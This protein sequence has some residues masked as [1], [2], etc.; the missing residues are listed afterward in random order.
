MIDKKIST[1]K[2]NTSEILR[3]NLQKR[4]DLAESLQKF[5]RTRILMLLWA[6]KELS[7]KDLCDKLGKSWPTVNRHLE[8]LNDAGVLD[9][10]EEKSP[11]PKNK[12][13]Y[14]MKPNILMYTRIAFRDIE[15]LSTE[16]TKKLFMKGFISDGK[17]MEILKS[18]LEDITP[19]FNVL[20][21]MLNME[22]IKTH[23]ALKKFMIENRV[24]YYIEALDEKEFEFYLKKYSELYNELVN[25]RKKRLEELKG[26]KIERPYLTCH[27]LLPIKKI[28]EARVQRIWQVPEMKSEKG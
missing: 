28:Q 26:E 13:L 11:G 24:S 9:V 16:D 10:R 18:V 12:K 5:T 14:S 21:D 20:Q 1:S 22:D 2:D 15:G 23:D 8:D 3:D 19:Y 17:T 4:L 25:F 7:V 27:M 6:Y